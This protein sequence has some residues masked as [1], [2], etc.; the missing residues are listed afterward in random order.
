M[1]VRKTTL[2]AALTGDIVNSTKLASRQ[3]QGLLE[4]LDSVLSG[5]VYEFYRGDSFQV[6]VEDP[7]RALRLALLCRAIAVGETEGE[8]DP[9]V[10]DIRIS[11]GIGPAEQPVR[12]LGKAKGE[13]FLLSGR[14]FDRLQQNEERLAIVCGEPTANIGFQA[15]ADYLD[16]IFKAM[17]AKQARVIAALL[18]RETQQTAAQQ[19]NRSKSTVSELAAAGRWPEIERLLEQ[20]EMLINRL[21]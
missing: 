20:Y 11:I 14:Q 6:Y 19:L 4:A 16:S 5:Y 8:E 15:M 21:S 18:Q 17:T 12:N 13:A 1:S 2:V 3:E 10:A 9:V 7:A